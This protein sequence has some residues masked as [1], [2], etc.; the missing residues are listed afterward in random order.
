MSKELIEQLAEQLNFHFIDSSVTIHMD[1]FDWGTTTEPHYIVTELELLEICKAY[2]AA[3][4]ID[5][6]IREL[7]ENDVLPF[8]VEFASGKVGKGCTL[9][10]VLL[11]LSAQ[12]KAVK[13]LQE[14]NHSLN[15][16]LGKRTKAEQ[17]RALIPDTQAEIEEG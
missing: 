11:R 9:K 4:P 7:S 3:A 13:E 15:R 1:G 10:T 12:N 16:K 8:D 5:N 17:L 6:V 2:Q 14:E